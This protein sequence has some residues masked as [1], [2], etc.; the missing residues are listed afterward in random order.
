V[1]IPMFFFGSLVYN[2]QTCI[3]MCIM[4]LMQILSNYE[5]PL[6]NQCHSTPIVSLSTLH[7]STCD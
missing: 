2:F 7:S 6:C 3:L 1:F 4:C 5:I